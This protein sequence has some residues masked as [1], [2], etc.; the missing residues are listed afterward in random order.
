MV[1]SLMILSFRLLSICL[2]SQ[3]ALAY[4]P[5]YLSLAQ[6]ETPDN[7]MK[8]MNMNG[9]WSHAAPIIGIPPSRP[10]QFRN[11]EIVSYFAM[12]KE[13]QTCDRIADEMKKWITKEVIFDILYSMS[14][15]TFS[16]TFLLVIKNVV[17]IFE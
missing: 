9:G 16:Y 8:L 2:V 13:Q 7:F 5:N 11:P 15:N 17:R 1:S 4:Q 12:N 6:N 3:Y 10:R 14:Q